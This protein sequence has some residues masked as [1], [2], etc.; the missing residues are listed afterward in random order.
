MRCLVI[1]NMS[2]KEESKRISFFINEFLSASRD[3]SKN[4]LQKAIEKFPQISYVSLRM[5]ILRTVHYESKILRVNNNT[6]QGAKII[7]VFGIE[8]SIVVLPCME[9][10]CGPQMELFLLLLRR[11]QK[12]TQDTEAVSPALRPHLHFLNTF[13]TI[14]NFALAEM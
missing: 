10:S 2:N 13:P 5:Y 6:A 11:S 8:E 14:L 1:L 9:G 7:K 3:S 12:E 4:R